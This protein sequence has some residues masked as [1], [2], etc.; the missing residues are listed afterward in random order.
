M[1]V[2]IRH[3]LDYYD[4]KEA[5]LKKDDPLWQEASKIRL[6]FTDTFIRG[7]DPYSYLTQTERD[8]AYLAKREYRYK[9]FGW[10]ISKAGFC[11]LLLSMAATFATRKANFYGF[12]LMPVFYYKFREENRLIFNKRFFDMCNVGEE[13]ELGRERNK[14]L[15]ICNELQGV[16]DF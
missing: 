15:R 16:E 2:K 13:F 6:N 7:R 10:S 8:R 12:A 11:S 1:S 14:V 4:K 9:V 3:L 5:E